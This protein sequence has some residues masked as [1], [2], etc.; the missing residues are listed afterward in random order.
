MY[1]AGAVKDN[2]FF[3]RFHVAVLRAE[4]ACLPIL[5]ILSHNCRY[6]NT[7]NV[8][9]LNL[10]SR[11]IQWNS[12]QSGSILETFT[13]TTFKK[14]KNA[15][16]KKGVI[17]EWYETLLSRDHNGTR[18]HL[19]TIQRQFSKNSSRRWTTECQPKK[20]LWGKN[21]TSNAWINLFFIRS[22]IKEERRT[23]SNGVPYFRYL[24]F[25]P[26]EMQFVQFPSLSAVP[27][28]I[29]RKRGRCGA[30]GVSVE[31][32]HYEQPNAKEGWNARTGGRY[33]NRKNLLANFS[34]IR[35]RR[36]VSP[37]AC[38]RFVFVSLWNDDFLES[39]DFKDY[40]WFVCAQRTDDSAGPLH[41]WNSLRLPSTSYI[42][43]KQ[44]KRS[45]SRR[46][47]RRYRREDKGGCL[48][49]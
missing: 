18:Q 47:M 14:R 24:V 1:A 22:T 7:F 37:S 23:F 21:F 44:E 36:Y 43:G 11:H 33:K 28:K 10:L 31:N 17:Q 35:F 46:L 39:H 4:H 19:F 13:E 25:I 16:R 38:Q 40:G 41:A 26:T 6:I 42:R 32:A 3:P 12:V 48:V 29:G 20:Y 2:Y 27:T 49:R 5:S 45:E 34:L 8:F 30:S 9:P 15:C